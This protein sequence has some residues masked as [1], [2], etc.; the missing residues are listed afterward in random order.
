MDLEQLMVHLLAA[1][2]KLH[3]EQQLV[4]QQLAK[5]QPVKLQPVQQ[6]LAQQQLAKLPPVQQLK[7]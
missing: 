4:E 2:V 7:L 3:L 5:L 6:Q 1:E